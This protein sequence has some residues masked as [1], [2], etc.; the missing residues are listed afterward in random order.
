MA[1]ESEVQIDGAAQDVT[2]S[3]ATSS[4]D[5]GHADGEGVIL[6][7]DNSNATSA[8]DD[9]GSVTVE[10]TPAD[11]AP[12]VQASTVD[13]NEA[14]STA[15]S[16]VDVSAPEA[17]AASSG[18]ELG[19]VANQAPVA[20]A[21]ASVFYKFQQNTLNWK[22]MLQKAW[23]G[24]KQKKL[25]N[26]VKVYGF[27]EKRKQTTVRDVE[28][29]MRCGSSAALRYLNVLVKQNQIRRVGEAGNRETYYQV[30]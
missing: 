9:A 16:A 10:Q 17:T 1:D 30:I 8:S 15:P 24:N 25:N 13:G 12:A 4:V 2:P 3:S 7:S 21:P 22:Q 29:F 11:T 18:E 5:S 27:M 28:L 19:H 23:A 14:S 20:A 26:V 6:P